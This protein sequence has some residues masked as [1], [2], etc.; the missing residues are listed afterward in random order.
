MKSFALWI[1]RGEEKISSYKMK[2]TLNGEN[3]IQSL[4]K[5][6]HIE[7]NFNYLVDC[8]EK[9]DCF[10][11][12]DFGIKYEYNDEM[13][14]GYICLFIPFKIEQTNI[15]DLGKCLSDNKEVLN[16]IFN[17]NYTTHNVKA[18]NFCNVYDKKACIFCIYALDIHHDISMYDDFEG[19][20]VKI[21][22]KKPGND[23]KSHKIYYRLRME[24]EVLQELK[25]VYTPGNNILLSSFE[26]N[27]YID[28]RFNDGRT[29]EARLIE[30][31][32]EEN[33]IP[34]FIEKFH[35]LLIT[36]AQV[37]VTASEVYT[38]RSLEKELWNAYYSKFGKKNLIVANH[39]HKKD[40]SGIRKISLLIKFRENVCTNGTILLYLIVLFFITVLFN[41]VS[42]FI[43]NYWLGL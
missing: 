38:E 16:S 6:C 30:E 12:L 19:T 39:W 22:V 11:A 23:C 34:V 25:K 42:A 8:M 7:I 40:E 1:E 9:K 28:F 27:S 31:M 36:K 21:R 13:Y 10:P 17:E 32:E 18:V 2:T 20:I 26:K 33:N 4:K 5:A 14:N 37:Q 29:L 15:S 41:G 24:A 3:E 43:W 35:F